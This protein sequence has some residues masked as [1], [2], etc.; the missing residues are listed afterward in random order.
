MRGMLARITARTNGQTRREAGTQSHGSPGMSGDSRVVETMHES[1]CAGSAGLLLIH[2]APTSFLT[3]GRR[4]PRALALP[5][6][7]LYS[8]GDRIA[9]HGSD[10]IQC[11][12]S[13]P[14]GGAAPAALSVPT[15]QIHAAR[16]IGPPSNLRLRRSR[17]L[18][19]R[20]HLLLGGVPGGPMCCSLASVR[21]C[22]CPTACCHPAAGAPCA[23]LT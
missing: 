5:R 23:R 11:P 8:R 2:A 13:R 6:C 17:G 4:A 21:S 1:V 9:R 15:R 12:S 3:T 7:S 14:Q 16:Q 22:G 10:V 18:R 19:T 20:G